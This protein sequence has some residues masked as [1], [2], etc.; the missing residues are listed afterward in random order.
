MYQWDIFCFLLHT[1]IVDD[2]LHLYI[3]YISLFCFT[4]SLLYPLL[5]SL[6]L[7]VP[8]LWWT[9]SWSIRQIANLHF[10]LHIQFEL[11]PKGTDSS[12]LKVWSMAGHI[13]ALISSCVDWGPFNNAI[14]SMD[15][16]PYVDTW[17]VWCSCHWVDSLFEKCLTNLAEVR[18]IFSSTWAS[19]GILIFAE[20]W[21]N[22]FIYNCCEWWIIS[23]NHHILCPALVVLLSLRQFTF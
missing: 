13:S 11:G 8:L 18:F 19:W 9:P 3:C 21:I 22:F 16:R 14:N 10:V 1:V 12:F 6:Y 20:S 4:S 7:P 17:S 5:L 15:K 23:T 2:R